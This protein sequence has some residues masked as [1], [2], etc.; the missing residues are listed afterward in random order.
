MLDFVDAAD[1]APDGK[2]LAIVRNLEGRS[3][4]EY[5]VG[6]VLVSTPVHIDSPRFSPQGDRIAFVRQDPKG[7][8]IGIVD[9]QGKT[10]LFPEAWQG[11]ASLAWEPSGQGIDFAASGTHGD[12][13]VYRIDLRGR[14]TP[15]VSIPDGSIVHDVA[16]DGRILLERYHPR[17]GIVAHPPD[18]TERDLTWFDLS[19]L[20]AMSADGSTVLFTE[21]S[22]AAGKAGAYFLRKTDGSAAVKLGD[23]VAYDLSPDGQSVLAHPEGSPGLVL[24][25]TGAGTAVP[26]AGSAIENVVGA[27]F[28]PDGKRIVVVG[29][30][31]KGGFRWYVQEIPGGAPRLLGFEGFGSSGKPISPDARFIVAFRDWQEDLFI[32]PLDGGRPRAIPD[33]KGLDPVGWTPDGRSI[34]ANEAQSLPARILKI[35]VATGA[36]TPYESLSPAAISTVISIRNPL[37]TADGRGYAFGY[38]AASSSDLYVVEVPR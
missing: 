4:L 18:S 16:R 3:R 1:W 37:L 28:F 11:V 26:L 15:V 8:A 22:A 29:A 23:G 31:A 38:S 14:P 13:T 5:P 27:E 12:S 2:D 20:V 17:R 21:R 33:T 36:R 25:P 34:Y 9:R 35:D 30:P 24:V 10:T 32:L 19:D 7:G 6:N